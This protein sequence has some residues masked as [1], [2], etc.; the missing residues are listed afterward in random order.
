MKSRLYNLDFFDFIGKVDDNSVDLL[1]TDP[2]Y[3]QGKAEW[4]TFS[5]LD[6]F[7]SFTYDWLDA[8]IPKIKENGSLYIFNNPFNSAFILT[9]LHNKGLFY[10]NTIIWNK[11]DGISG[12]KRRYNQK[13]EHILFFT[14]H[15]TNYTFNYD[16]IRT[17]YE[18]TK[19]IDA[20]KKKG[21]LKN[22]KRWTP[23]EK[24]KLCG[25][26]W[27]F[28]SYRHKNKINGKVVHQQHITPKPLD[29]LERIVKA[30]SN[31]ND[32]VMD[33]FMGSGTTGMVC[34]KLN[35]D[36]IGNDK[37]KI[38]YEITKNNIFGNPE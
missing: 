35:R 9:Y 13:Q 33:P 32:V 24:G 15:K 23:N 20:A 12:T 26:V 10:K 22:G 30:S 11:K 36:F 25:D 21:I 3:N 8:I 37:N 6:D 18:S 27:Y 14:K 5:S 19:R 34:K 4:D 2:P 17:A 29:L 7:L 1:L 38:Y 16:D 31:E 28:S